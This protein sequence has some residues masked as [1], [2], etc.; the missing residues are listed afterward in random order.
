M[1]LPSKQLEVQYIFIQ[2]K[3]GSQHQRK[4]FDVRKLCRLTDQQEEAL[5]E[6]GAK[7][8]TMACLRQWW[9]KGPIDLSSE[10]DF[11]FRLYDK[12]NLVISSSDFCV[13]L[14]YRSILNLNFFNR[15]IFSWV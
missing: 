1:L 9:A 8:Q 10:T 11:I 15:L 5:W 13:S 12:Y 7:I 6:A 2:Q 14:L 3:E 4:Y